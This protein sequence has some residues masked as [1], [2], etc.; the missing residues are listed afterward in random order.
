VGRKTVY[1]QIVSDKDWELVSNDNKKLIQE[2]IAY[3]HS[4]NRSLETISQYESQLRIFFTWVLNNANNDYFPNIKKRSFINFIG[5]G[6]N[7][8]WS[9]ARVNSL[10]SVLSS[11][12]NYFENCYSEEFPTFHNPIKSLSTVVSEPVREKTILDDNIIAETLDKLIKDKE[13]QLATFLSILANSGM[14]RSETIQLMTDYFIP[15]RIVYNTF[16]KSP[17]LKCKGRG[18]NGKRL[19]RYIFIDG[20]QKY[21]DLWLDERKRLGINIPNLFVTKEKGEY[22]PA[23]ISTCNTFANKISEVMGNFYYNHC[24]RHYF[25]SKLKKSG[26]SNEIIMEIIK[27]S[28]EKM[29]KIYSD[30]DEGEEKLEKFFIN[31]GN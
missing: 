5:Y 18:K 16:Y 9:P 3:L 12:S 22:L 26:V 24:V 27:W 28:D 25:V 30:F 6:F 19:S 21:L 10:K 31:Q 8:G 15:E 14:R 11:L 2:F 20:F 1:N 23:K 29:I 13:Y 17:P 7:L 4:S